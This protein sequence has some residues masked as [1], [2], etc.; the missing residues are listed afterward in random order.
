MRIVMRIV[1][2]LTRRGKADGFTAVELS[3]MRIGPSSTKRAGAGTINMYSNKEI[4]KKYFDSVSGESN[5]PITEYFS[6]DIEWNLPPA[7]PF[8]GPFVGIPAVLEMMGRGGEFFKFETISIDIHS[9][10]SEK[11]NVVAHFRLTAKTHDERD[12]KNEYIFRFLCS[13]QKISVVWE[14][15]DT[16][17]LHQMGMFD[18]IG[19]A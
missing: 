17:Y 13:N 14:F 5:I 16:Y 11:E 7:H 1:K 2:Q 8:G 10:I 3:V 4:I 18:K 19:L 15:L 6:D 12:Y 9:L